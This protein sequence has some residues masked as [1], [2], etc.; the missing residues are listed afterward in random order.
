VPAAGPQLPEAFVA[1]DRIEPWPK[2]VGIAE[3]TNPLPGDEK[4]VVDGIGS[5]ISQY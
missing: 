3:L 5:R 4:R 2:P 1:H